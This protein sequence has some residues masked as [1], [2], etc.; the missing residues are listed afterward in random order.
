M[1]SVTLPSSPGPSAVRPRLVDHGATLKGPL[2]GASQRVNRLGN[3][4]AFDIDMPVM[5][6]ADAR[7]WSASLSKALRSGVLWQVRQVGLAIGSPGSPL[8]NGAAQTGQSLIADGF[9]AGYTLTAGQFFSIYDGGSQRYLHMVQADVTA[10]G[11]GNATPAIEPAL[12]KSPGD[13]DVIEVA[14]PYIE[15]LL[16]ESPSWSLDPDRLARGFSFTIEEVR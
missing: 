16:A 2:G 4:W 6:S 8:V 11:S 12:R 14:L 13:N 5:S 7:I 10:D 15:G 1:G 3:R 9:T